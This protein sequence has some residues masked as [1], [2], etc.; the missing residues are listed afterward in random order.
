MNLITKRTLITAFAACAPLTLSGAAS[1]GGRVSLTDIEAR[2]ANIEA[3]QY[4]PFKVQIGGGVCNSAAVGSSNP[5]ITI[6]S[7]AASGTF[8]VT[9]VLIKTQDIPLAGFQFLSLNSLI[10]DGISYD[11][12][13]PN[14]TG[15]SGGSGVQ[16]SFEMLGAPVALSGDLN[17]H[18]IG[19][20]VP[21]EIVA[22]SAGVGDIIF[23]MFCRS[24]VET[25]TIANVVV[26]GWK[27]P[28]E[29]VTV[30]YS[31]GN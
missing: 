9:S 15:S 24:D 14:L 28:S 17:D 26:A 2:L 10:L 5:A 20:S 1:A 7:D 3:T 8:M 30:T 12:K 25:M 18:T 31:P 23:Q 16:E 21:R 27:R 19:A 13:T 22:N 6:D 29:T 11:T 4:V